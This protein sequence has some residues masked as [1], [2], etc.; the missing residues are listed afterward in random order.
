M[1]WA[2][3]SGPVPG[4]GDERE[5]RRARREFILAHHPDRGGDPAVFAA[6]LAALGHPGPPAARPRVVVVP[7]TPWLVAL[8]IAM[9]RRACWR[10]APPRVR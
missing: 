5:W 8:V 1:S 2:A 3:T 10:S 6:G 7:D 4:P 9:A